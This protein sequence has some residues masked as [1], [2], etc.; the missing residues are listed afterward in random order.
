MTPFDDISVQKTPV[1][2]LDNPLWDPTPDEL[3]DL[4]PEEVTPQTPEN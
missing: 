1:F 4:V 2:D 3:V